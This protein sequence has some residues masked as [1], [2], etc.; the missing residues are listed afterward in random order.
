[1][2]QISN[3]FN[4]IIKRVPSTLDHNNASNLSANNFNILH[5]NIQSINSK[6]LDL[7]LL[8]NELNSNIDVICVDEHWL[9]ASQISSV[10]LQN[11]IIANYYCR[12][13]V[14]HGGTMIFVKDNIKI[15]PLNMANY[16]NEDQ[17]FE[18]CVIQ[19]YDVN[20]IIIAVCRSPLGNFDIFL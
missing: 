5:L 3:Q 1:M 7:E 8:L 15:K 16:L 13:R 20:I 12:L 9:N 19:V 14:K 2:N 6:T 4:N 17:I 10:H 18:G 11:Y